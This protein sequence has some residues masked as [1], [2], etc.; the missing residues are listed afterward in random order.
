[1][2]SE[3]IGTRIH[4]VAVFAGR[5]NTRLDDLAETPLLSMTP[6]E[7]RASLRDGALAQAS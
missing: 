7:V 4:P 2:T 5:L 3:L 6:A 1:M